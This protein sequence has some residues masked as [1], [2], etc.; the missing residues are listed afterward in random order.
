MFACEAAGQ[1]DAEPV[2]GEVAEPAAGSL[3]L[4]DQQVR[5][6]DGTVGCAGR[7]MVQDLGAP[8][9]QR[10][11]ESAE[12]RSGFGRGAPCDR[13]VE[14]DLRDDRIVGEIDVADFL[15]R[16]PTVLKVT[17][18]SPSRNAAQ[19]RSQPDSSTRSAPRRNNFRVEYNG[20]RAQPR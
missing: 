12:F 17:V 8:P 15:F 14:R 9:P 18:G 20:S 10:L 11:R 13:I 5:G 16:D 3:D 6:F 1:Q 2:V 19:I 4:L 7:V